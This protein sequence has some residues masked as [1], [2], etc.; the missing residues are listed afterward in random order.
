MAKQKNQ[1]YV[2]KFYLKNFSAD[3]KNLNIYV[4]KDKKFTQ[5]SIEDQCSKDYFYSKDTSL[6]TFLSQ[7]ESEESK[8]VKNLIG[9][10]SLAKLSDEDYIE[11]L[12]CISLMHGRTLKRKKEVEKI[13]DD[14]VEKILK[15]AFRADPLSTDLTDENI[16]SINLK[17][18]R[19]HL[20]GVQM[21][22]LGGILLSDLVPVLLVNNTE[23]EFW[24]SD[25]PTVFYNGA[26]HHL[27]CV[28]MSGYTSY[29]LQVFFPL[30][31]NLGL[32]LVHSPYYKIKMSKSQKVKLKIHDV[33]EINKLQFFSGY[34]A[35]FYNNQNQK[36]YIEQLHNE[37]GTIPDKPF[38]SSKFEKFTSEEGIKDMYHVSNGKIPYKIN[39]KFIKTTKFGAG[40]IDSV[41]N[42]KLFDLFNEAMNSK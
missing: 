37:L 5:G 38:V 2:P 39:L 28:C 20:L 3:K 4:I 19:L 35:L 16:K 18:P 10:K 15:P 8:A 34:N 12:R 17:Y 30:S 33:K 1:H 31:P 36:R 22:I 40:S 7:I 6:E 24:I 26:F 9:E 25:H 29:G 13:F 42:K 32:L 41:R 23:I 27:N 11:I 21:G 14:F